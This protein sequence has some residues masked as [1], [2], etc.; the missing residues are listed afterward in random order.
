MIL[1]RSLYWSSWKWPNADAD[2][3][4]TVLAEP[5]WCNIICALRIWFCNLA[6]F[7]LWLERWRSC[8]SKWLWLV[9][10]PEPVTPLSNWIRRD[11]SH[12]R[13]KS[14]RQLPQHYALIFTSSSQLVIYSSC[15][16][17]YMRLQQ[18]RLLFIVEVPIHSVCILTEWGIVQAFYRFITIDN[19]KMVWSNSSVWETP[20]EALMQRW[21][22]Q[23]LCRM[24]QVTY[25]WL[26]W[27]QS[28][29]FAFDNKSFRE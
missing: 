29:H 22:N 21:G 25:V 24:C 19:N 27:I 20:F 3:F 28:I 7:L 11:A 6:A 5:N 12:I 2:V 26:C 14:Y 10:L 8:L 23:L 4:W 18:Q 16:I 1:P 13:D 15:Q 9:V 17:V